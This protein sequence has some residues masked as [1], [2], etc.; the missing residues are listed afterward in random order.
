MKSAVKSMVDKTH[1]WLI[2][3]FR[4]LFTEWGLAV[5][6]IV[7]MIV[8]TL[9]QWLFASEQFYQI[10]VVNTAG[11]SLLEKLKVVTDGWYNLFRYINDITPASIVAIAFFQ[12]SI[13]AIWYRVHR[14]GRPRISR[15]ALGLGLLGSGCVACGGSLLP[16]LASV[17]GTAV[18]AS[19]LQS[20]GN[21]LLVA[22]SLMAATA[23]IQYANRAALAIIHD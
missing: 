2:V 1:I 5:F 12:A 20:I 4:S 22:A 9:L 8:A 15:A 10:F 3:L 23:A 19:T 7:F 13:A 21:F 17:F 18:S 6:V 16:L 11:L 14:L